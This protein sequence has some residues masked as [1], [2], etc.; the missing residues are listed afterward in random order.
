MS[1]KTNSN[2]IN[3]KVADSDEF[4]TQMS[5]IEKELSHYLNHFENAI[6]YCNCDDPA[7]SNF[8]HF[9]HLNFNNLGLKKLIATFYDP[10]KPVYKIEYTG[11]NDI[12]FRE[13]IVTELEGNG[14][15]ASPECIET[16]READ[17]V[18]TNP[19]FSLF[20][21]YVALLM[22]YQKKFL[23]IGN[24]NAI[25]YKEFFPLIKENKIWS[26]TKS[27]S[28]GMDMIFSADR[29]DPSKLKKYKMDLNGNYLV[30]VMGVVW[31]TNLNLQKRHVPISLKKRYNSNDYVHYDNYDGIEVPKVS[32]IPI[33]YDGVMG[34]P[35][36][37]LDKHCPEQFEIIGYGQ[38]DLFIDAGGTGVSAEFV[39]RYYAAGNTGIIKPGWKHIVCYRDGQ[40]KVPYGRVLI[41]HK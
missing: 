21:K 28:G 11:G 36:S 9:F 29:F 32:D 31:Y 10:E 5:D 15:F 2:L 1:K 4:Y 17:I 22:E 12:D 40:P 34:V 27:F 19:P 7:R 35:V 37:F 41:R 16:L 38:G 39:N 20:R 25:T 13:G 24:M 3:A 14:D 18:V 8:W 33:D 6:I 23:I 30:N 26:G